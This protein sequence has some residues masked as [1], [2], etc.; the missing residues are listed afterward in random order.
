MPDKLKINPKR[1][2]A[3]CIAFTL[4]LAL[5]ASDASFAGNLPVP[6][7]DPA[8]RLEAKRAGVKSATSTCFTPGAAAMDANGDVLACKD[9]HWVHVQNSRSK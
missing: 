3:A 5:V 7:A 1:L 6:Q 2:P 4:G 8:L 9:R